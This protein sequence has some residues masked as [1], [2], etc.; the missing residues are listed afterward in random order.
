M[1]NRHLVAR[2]VRRWPLLAPS[3]AALVSVSAPEARRPVRRS[4]RRS[5]LGFATASA[6][7]RGTTL[8]LAAHADG[9]EEC[10][11]HLADVDAVL[12]QQ[13]RNSERTHSGSP[14]VRDGTVPIADRRGARTRL[15][16]QRRAIG[17]R[18]CSSTVA[19]RD[20]VQRP[21]HARPR[22][23]NPSSPRERDQP[24]LKLE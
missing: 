7:G 2:S 9:V 16:V 8:A 1:D 11:A 14:P 13:A 21:V 5:A 12:R 6:R 17:S 19:A 15:A 23:R 3:S 20:P 10:T 22:Q 18:L 24:K 4:S